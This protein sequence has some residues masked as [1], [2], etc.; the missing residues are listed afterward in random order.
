ML[1]TD[2][3][4]MMLGSAS[5]L[6]LYGYTVQCFASLRFLFFCFFFVFFTCD[7]LFVSMFETRHE[8]LYIAG[9]PW[10]HMMSCDARQCLAS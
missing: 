8:D 6:T 5:H 1:S 4:R 10:H 9:I 2:A 7:I 3:H